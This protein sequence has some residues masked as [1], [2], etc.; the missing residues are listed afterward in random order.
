MATAAAR[1]TSVS[2]V[3]DPRQATSE[4]LAP[5]PDHSA[6]RD[7]DG[8]LQSALNPPER[9]HPACGS[10]ASLPAVRILS[11]LRIL[12]VCGELSTLALS[13]RRRESNRQPCP[14]TRARNLFD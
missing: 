1:R 6:D 8:R 9:T 11:A 14:D 3:P 7:S 10:R 4:S 12:K 2:R 13:P 5:I